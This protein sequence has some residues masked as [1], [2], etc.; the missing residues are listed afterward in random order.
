MIIL[1]KF[2]LDQNRGYWDIR[3]GLNR[4]KQIR[5][6][7]CR[8]WSHTC[9]YKANI[10]TVGVGLMQLN[11][12]NL[13]DSCY[14]LSFF[15]CFKPFKYVLELHCIASNYCWLLTRHPSYIICHKLDPVWRSAVPVS[16]KIVILQN[17]QVA[18]MF[19]M[20]VLKKKEKI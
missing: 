16:L 14:Q 17:I 15:A 5:L 13:L 12:N 19:G 3:P 18:R 1:W 7:L 8:W 11:R 10:P 6:L 4:Q 9:E 20:S 2:E